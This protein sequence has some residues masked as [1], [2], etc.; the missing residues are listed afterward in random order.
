MVYI[1]PQLV[2]GGLQAAA[3]I[4]GASAK[5]RSA[6]DAARRDA[7]VRN[8]NALRTY[9]AD[10]QNYNRQVKYQT[11]L[12]NQ[13]KVQYQQQ[14]QFNNQYLA[15]AYNESQ[16]N[17]Q[18]LL[19][20][21]STKNLN[22]LVKYYQKQGQTAARGLTGSTAERISAMNEAALGRLQSTRQASYEAAKGERINR[23]RIARMRTENLNNQAY[24]R[25]AVPPS[26]AGPPVFGGLMQPQTTNTF[27]LDAANAVLGGVSTAFS[28]GWNPFE[29]PGK[30]LPQS[31]IVFDDGMTYE[32][33][34]AEP[35]T[36]DQF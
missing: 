35:Y 33:V 32:Q 13:Q 8:R 1:P 36:A 15:E 26:F 4:F 23:D 21:T 2:I 17:L 5:Q 18:N 20:Q 34:I 30:T 12:Y 25:V 22:S 10:L 14:L 28:G 16:L 29:K 9:A 24:A 11:D 3:G 27:G 7:K 6:N 31:G 19:D